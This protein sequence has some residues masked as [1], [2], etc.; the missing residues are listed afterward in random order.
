[1]NF[2]NSRVSLNSLR[3]GYNPYTGS[4]LGFTATQPL[5]RGFGAS[6]NRRFIRI[7]GNEQKITSL[8]FQQQLI[9]TVYGVIRLYT[10][11]VALIE[12]EKVKQET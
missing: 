9:L 8:L 11:L 6:L 7:A 12:D 4:T 2:N 10:D 5:L 3:S 1:M